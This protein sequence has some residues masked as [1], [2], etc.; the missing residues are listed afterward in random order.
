MIEYLLV[1]SQY[2][3][4][5]KSLYHNLDEE[6]SDALSPLR[7][8]PVASERQWANQPKLFFSLCA[9]RRRPRPSALAPAQQIDLGER[10]CRHTSF[11]PRRVHE[12]PEEE[13]RLTRAVCCVDHKDDRVHLDAADELDPLPALLRA[14]T[15][16]A[17]DR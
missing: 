13:E 3:T 16:V 1:V 11:G 12:L 7:T 14:A 6:A 8:Q 5:S 9:P 10:D 4:T 2:R 17:D 15:S